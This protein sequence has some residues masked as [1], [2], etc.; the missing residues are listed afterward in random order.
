[1]RSAS[2]KSIGSLESPL[3]VLL[4]NKYWQIWDSAPA[5]VP[6]P[7]PGQDAEETAAE[8]VPPWMACALNGFV[9][10]PLARSAGLCLVTVRSLRQPQSRLCHERKTLF[11]TGDTLLGWRNGRRVRLRGAWGNLWGFESPPEHQSSFAENRGPLQAGRDI[12]NCPALPSHS[13]GHKKAAAIRG[14]C[15][16]R[17]RINLGIICRKLRLQCIDWCR[18]GRGHCCRT[19]HIGLSH[20]LLASGGRCSSRC[21]ICRHPRRIQRSCRNRY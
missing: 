12:K 11:H 20:R 3:S 16:G 19:G 7:G 4:A 13:L 14:N 21:R 8:T 9:H 1:M 10:N 17:R 6:G 5:P 2:S 18:Q 15:G